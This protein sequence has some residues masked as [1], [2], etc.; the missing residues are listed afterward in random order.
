MS[1]QDWSQPQEVDSTAAVMG[2][3]TTRSLLPKR[4]DIPA[5]FWRDSHPWAALMERWF[6]EGLP[7][8]F[9][10]A[11]EGIPWKRA[12]AHLAAVMRSFDPSHKHKIAG[13]AYLCS[14]W[15]LD[16]LTETKPPEFPRF[17]PTKQVT[18]TGARVRP[19]NRRKAVSQ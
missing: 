15:F 5:E 9:L 11:R 1:E 12:V 7:G 19:G 3:G 2:A 13:C 16:P 14:R 10:R 8:S 4:E 18:A 17:A 6:F